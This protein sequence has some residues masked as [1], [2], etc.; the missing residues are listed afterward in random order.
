MKEKLQ[1]TLRIL[2]PILFACKTLTVIGQTS[3]PLISGKIYSG[4]VWLIDVTNVASYTNYKLMSEMGIKYA[5]IGGI[6]PNYRSIYKWTNGTWAVNNTSHIADLV[7]VI[8]SLRKY[9]IEPIIQVGY[10]P[11]CSSP[12][13][14]LSNTVTMANQAT[15]AANLVSALNSVYT[16]TANHINYYIIANEPDLFSQCPAINADSLKGFGY[17]TTAD[18]NLIAAYTRTFSAAMKGVDN[19]IKIIGPELATYGNDKGGPINKMMDSLMSKPSRPCSVMGQISA[20]V[21]YVDII[22]IHH[23]PG[24][25]E[26]PN[27]AALIANPTNSVNGIQQC[28]S[29]PATFTSGANPKWGLVNSMSTHYSN[30]GRDISNLKF[31]VTEMNINLGNQSISE[32]GTGYNGVIRGVDNRSFAGGQWIVDAFSRAMETSASNSVTSTNE[33]NIEFMAP[34]SMQEGDCNYGLGFLSGCSSHPGKK[35]PSF[36]HYQL[37]AQNFIDSASFYRGTS[38]QTNVKAFACTRLPYGFRIMILNQDT[39]NDYNLHINTTNTV[40]AASGSYNLQLDFD[41]TG[42]Q[43][44]NIMSGPAPSNSVILTP[45]TGTP[46]P[47]RK[48]STVVLTFDCYGNLMHRVDYTR[49]DAIN[50]MT[51]KIKQIGNQVVDP[52]MIYCGMPGGIGGTLSSNTVYSN[53]TVVVSSNLSLNPNVNLTF[54]NCLVVMEAG[55]KISSSRSNIITL[56]K[57]IMVGCEG[58]IFQGIEMSGFYTGEGI[59]VDSSLIVNADYPLYLTKIPNINISQS[60][61]VNGKNGITLIKPNAFSITETMIGNFTSG[62]RTQQANSGYQ[63]YIDKCVTLVCDTAIYSESSTHDSLYITCN[64]LEFKNIGIYSHS[65]TLKDFGTSAVGAG[66]RFIKT[67]SQ[68][69]TDFIDHSGNNP[70]Y[71]YDPAFFSSFNSGVSATNITENQAAAD[72]SCPTVVTETCGIW[73]TIGVKENSK[74]MASSFVVYPNP[75]SGTFNLSSQSANGKYDFTVYDIT[76]REIL[77]RKVNFTSEKTVSFDLKT[78]GMYIATLK[79]EKE[80]ITKKI[81]VQ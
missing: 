53:T 13:V 60:A 42:D 69:Q 67:T 16:T 15:I 1:C 63:S 47:I 30:T 10:N 66:N 12:V 81:I 28:I 43:T 18:A 36:Y 51:P 33:S 6:D 41:F 58:N 74:T 79:N 48:A 73:P 38:N 29:T 27:M 25:T 40:V 44:V 46:N 4:N 39:T 64:R 35:R 19:T 77:K 26:I 70:T 62:I 5:R 50:D 80:Q 54:D 52:S 11:I 68:S 22:S 23:Y 78:R 57:S 3:A 32:S 21:Y 37:L 24:T 49:D 65:S 31:S 45:I 9:G 17:S 75:S 55:T 34:W 71:N 56:N 72:A 8:D 14:L 76:G 20:G 59:V 7:S 61:F 2:L